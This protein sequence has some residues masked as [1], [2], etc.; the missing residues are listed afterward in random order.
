MTVYENNTCIKLAF[1]LCKKKSSSLKN[2]FAS[3]RWLE[4]HLWFLTNSE[5][6]LRTQ[7]IKFLILIG[8]DTWLFKKSGL[9]HKVEW[10]WI[11]QV[12][13]VGSCWEKIDKGFRHSQRR[14]WRLWRQW[15]GTNRRIKRKQKGKLSTNL[16][17]Y[18]FL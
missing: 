15:K 5:S 10:I 9:M 13:V 4:T 18:I 17:S 3:R 11:S 7:S 8:V 12:N 16:G 14:R 6:K 2:K 1:Q